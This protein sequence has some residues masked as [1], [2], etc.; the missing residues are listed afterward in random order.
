MRA[1]LAKVDWD[2]PLARGIGPAAARRSSRSPREGDD[3]LFEAFVVHGAT[4]PVLRAQ[5]YRHKAVMEELEVEVLMRHAGADRPRRP[6]GRRPRGLPT[7]A[8]RPGRVRPAL[9]VR[10]VVSPTPLRPSCSCSGWPTSSSPISRTRCRPPRR[11]RRE[12]CRPLGGATLRSEMERWHTH[13]L[14]EKIDPEQHADPGQPG[15]RSGSSRRGRPLLRR[16]SHHPQLRDHGSHGRTSCPRWAESSCRWR[17]RSAP[18]A[19]A[20]GRRWPDSWP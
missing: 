20:S 8:G 19:P 16:V 5:G 7:G 2:E 10:G 15:L 13:V 12:A 6:R 11:R 18:S 3:R 17:T 14:R 9:S 1:Q 4:D